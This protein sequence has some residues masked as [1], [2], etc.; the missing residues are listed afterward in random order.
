MSDF[1]C[2]NSHEIYYDALERK[3]VYLKESKE[4]V[5]HMCKIMEEALE[6]EAKET[7]LIDIKNL[8]SS[9]KLSAKEA[10][11]ALCILEKEQ[12]AYLKMMR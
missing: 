5:A 11:E 10:M 12:T 1:R 4:G 6:Q 8:M 3:A 2:V 7:R 9:L